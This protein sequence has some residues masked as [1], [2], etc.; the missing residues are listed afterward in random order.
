MIALGSTER[1]AKMSNENPRVLRCSADVVHY[2]GVL[3]PKSPGEHKKLRDAGGY[4][5]V[6]D[7]QTM[8]AFFWPYLDEA[9]V[10][11]S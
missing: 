4:N 7:R 6:R 5:L 11:S 2:L 8:S 1:F 3:Q 10:V 9:T